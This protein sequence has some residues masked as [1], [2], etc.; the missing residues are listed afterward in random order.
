MALK[1]NVSVPVVTQSVVFEDAY[2]TAASIVGSKDSMSVSVEMRTVRGGDVIL[3]RSYAFPYDL[4]GADNAF[5][6][7]YLHLKTLPEFANAVD[8]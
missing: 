7:A 5:R 8:C 1:M 4:A 3:M 6:Q 2:C